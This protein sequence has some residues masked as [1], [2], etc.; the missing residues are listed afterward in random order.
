MGAVEIDPV[1]SSL[2]RRDRAPSG[3]VT[4]AAAVRLVWM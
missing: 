2:S 4:T 1:S 3:D